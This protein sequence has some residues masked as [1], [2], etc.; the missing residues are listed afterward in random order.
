MARKL[1][2]L[3]LSLPFLFLSA[4]G[5]EGSTAT[6]NRI[7][8]NRTV[9]MGSVP[10]EAP[11][12]YQDGQEWVG[13]DAELGMLIVERIKEDV[14]GGADASDIE[15]KFIGMQHETLASALENSEVDLVL[16][17]FGITEDRKEKVLFSE[18]YYSL[19]LVLSINPVY[20]DLRPDSL[21]GADIGVREG[22]AVEQFVRGKFQESTIVPFKTLDDA[23]LALRRGEI[24][25]VIDDRYMSAFS[26]DT[27]PGVA[28][29]ELLPTTVGTVD[30]AVAV[31]KKDTHLL[32]M[33][34]EI[35]AQ[36]K[37]DG[38][39][40]QW[41]QGEPEAQLARVLERHPER[42][43]KDRKAVEPRRLV[44]QISKDDNYDFDIYRM[45]NLNF[46]LTEQES[47]QSFT[48]SRIDFQSSTGVSS[49]TVP[50]GT[51][52][53]MVPKMNNWSP[54]IVVVQPSDPNRLT[55]RI[56]LQRGG[57]VRLTRS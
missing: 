32:E 34:N 8:Q 41:L 23:I 36:V 53:L 56:R 35:I 46:T 16:G 33:V 3:L 21:A 55:I 57:Q 12:L 48:S 52:K 51:Y 50:P 1:L 19:D 11:L 49:I 14:G 5:G 30:C 44:I 4:C 22:T 7:Q 10:F 27:V 37:T 25:G 26:L 47:G 54:G 42:L 31:Q 9:T 6:F 43:E 40:T 45:A 20:G 13:P 17:V 2:L 24:T 18:P 29:L 38:G 39:Y 15:G 28:H